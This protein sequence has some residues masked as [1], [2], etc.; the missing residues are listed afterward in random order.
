MIWFPNKFWN[1]FDYFTIFEWNNHHFIWNKVITTGKHTLFYNKQEDYFPFLKIFF[2]KIRY[3][4][5]YFTVDSMYL[6]PIVINKS[7]ADN[8]SYITW[9]S[10][11][12]QASLNNPLHSKRKAGFSQLAKLNVYLMWRKRA[13]I[14]LCT[15]N[16]IK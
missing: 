1:I 9:L 14:D 11:I 13:N 10:H 2:Y 4:K 12:V 16:K 5:Q 6:L 15:G 8:L 7:F 3:I